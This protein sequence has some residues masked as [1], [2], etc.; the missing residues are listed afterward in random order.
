MDV[1]GLQVPLSGHIVKNVV[2]D[3]RECFALSMD[4]IN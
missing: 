1:A 3:P 4:I 2:L